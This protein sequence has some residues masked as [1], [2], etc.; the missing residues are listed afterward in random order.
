MLAA[1]DV[2]IVVDG[3][4]VVRD[5]AFGNE[6]LRRE[7]GEQ[8]RWVGRRW[9]S[10]MTV[11]S[12]PKLDALLSDAAADRPIRWRHLNHLAREGPDL[13]ISYSAVQLAHD[14]SVIVLGRDLRSASA[15]QQRLVE[16]QQALERDYASLRQAE[17]RYRMLFDTA[18]DAIAILDAGTTRPIE[19]NPAA[20]QLLGKDARR[21]GRGFAD[22]FDAN[23]RTIINAALA[24]ARGSGRSEP[25]Q[26][27]LDGTTVHLAISSLREEDG[28]FLLVRG[29]PQ[30]L[31]RAEPASAD[32]RAIMPPLLEQIPD[33]VVLTDG[34]GDVLSVN[35]A[36]RSLAGLTS[37]QVVNN[38]PLS[39]WV[40]QEGVDLSVLLANL[41]QRGTVRLFSTTLRS[42]QGGTIDIEI[43]ASTLPGLQDGFAFFMRDISRRLSAES[44]LGRGMAQSADQMS[45]LIGRVSLKELVREST[46]AIERLC[47][48]SALEMTGNNRA[49]AA[50]MLGLSRQSLY[51]K[52]RRYG[53]SDAEENQQ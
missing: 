22:L 16:T 29:T 38:E 31:G 26:A 12:R 46:D 3:S 50:E 18:Q 8:R 41:R 13:P 5:L 53:L 35:A 20:R 1:S 19:L 30:R 25:V 17:A 43:S 32:E 7:I 52:L 2:A 44:R 4:G 6:Q 36:F 39:R 47:I 15:L 33:S 23:S 42:E 14:N 48:E 49:S 28:R 37:T 51:V 40:G 10:T 34:D 21:G 24:T 11:E 45:E 27:Q 9:R